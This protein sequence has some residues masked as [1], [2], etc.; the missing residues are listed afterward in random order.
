VSAATGLEIAVIGMSCRVPGAAG[1]EGFWDNLRAGRESISFFSEE[2]LLAAGHS[3]DAIRHPDYVPAAGTLEGIDRFD[4]EFFGY[5]P[6]EAQLIDPQQRLFLEQAWAA[7]ERAGYDPGRAGGPVGVFGGSSA[8]TYLFTLLGNPALWELANAYQTGLEKDFLATRVAYKLDL[9]G[10][11]VV[12]QTACSSSLAAIHLACQSLL[13][14]ECDM[15]LAGGVSVSVPQVS[16]YRYAVDGIRSRDGHCRPFDAAATGAVKGSGVGVVV[17]KRLSDAQRDRDPIEAV[18]RGSAMNN[19]GARKVGYTAPRVEGQCRVIEAALALAEVPPE[20]VGYVEA[21]GTGTALGDPIEVAALTQAFGRDG[22]TGRCALGSVKSNIG[23]LDAAAGV[24]GLIKAALMLKHRQMV[25]SLHFESPNPRLKLESSPFRIS[26]RSEP[27]A[28]DGVPRRCGVSSFGIGGTNVHVVL[29]EAPQADPPRDGSG[30]HLLILSARTASALEHQTR[31]L[32]VH[33]SDHPDLRLEDV[34][35]T[36]REG[37]RVFPHRRAVVVED[38]RAALGRLTGKQGALTSGLASETPPPVAFLFPGQGAQHPGMAEGLYEAHALFRQELDECCKVLESHLGLDL[39]TAL[40]PEGS[41]RDEAARSLAETRLTQPALFAVEYALA[42]LWMSWGVTPRAMIGHSIGEYV[43]ASLA[44]V[45][46]RDDALGLVA[47]RGRLM[48]SC[49]R[50]AMLAVAA[51]PAD[52]QDRLGGSLVVAVHNAPDACVVAGP[53]EDVLLLE[54]QLRQDQTAAARVAT[55]HAFHSPM[56]EGIVDEY[57]NRVAQVPLKSP[58]IPFLSNLTGTWITDGEAIDPRYWA[59]H[60]RETVRFEEGLG[61]LLEDRPH[62]LVEVGPGQTLSTLAR[63]RLG[64]ES[65]SRV[66]AS[67]PHRRQS[68]ADDV[69]LLAAAGRLWVEGVAVEWSGGDSP[70]RRVVLPTY[71][72]EGKRH[73]AD[74]PSRAAKPDVEREPIDRWFHAPV[75]R[76]HPP[77]SATVPAGESV[78]VLA[79]EEVGEAVAG[80]LAASGVRVTVA[81]PGPAPKR[82]PDGGFVV[83]PG[84]AADLQQVSEALER[85]GAP[86]SKVVHLWGLAHGEADDERMETGFFTVVALG[87]ILPRLAAP[88]TLTVVTRGAQ[89]VTGGETLDPLAALSLGPCRVIPQEH[90]DVTC[91]SV[92]VIVGSLQRRVAEAIVAEVFGP[93]DEVAVAYRGGYRWTQAFERVNVSRAGPQPLRKEGVYLIT[94]GLGEVGLDVAT[95]LARSA[96]ARLVLTSR[97][98]LPP[99]KEWAGWLREHPDSDPTGTT[100]RAVSRLHELGAE[101]LVMA[102][103]VGDREAMQRV[104]A[105]ARERF[106]AVNGV[107]HAAG[108]RDA[109]RLVARLDRD[110]ALRQ[111]W[112]K[113][114]GVRVLEELAAGEDF[115]FVCLTSSLASILGGLGFAA[116]AAANQFLDL[117]AHARCRQSRVPWLSVNWDGWRSRAASKADGRQP[118]TAEEGGEAFELALRQAGQPQLAVSTVDLDTR[119]AEWVERRS[120]AAPGVE[121]SSTHSRPE[122][123]TVFVAPESRVE[124]RLAEVWGILLGIDRVG[125]DDNF[126]E[127]GGSSLLAV[128]LVARLRNELR[129]ELSVATLFEAPTVRSLAKRLGSGPAPDEGLGRSHER[130]QARKDIRSRRTLDA[131]TR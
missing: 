82:C 8:S 83:R 75:W 32:A 54:E 45:V 33:L 93:G 80:V 58:R 63:R 2:E 3:A 44:G 21:H 23:H 87:Q 30:P 13:A 113:V 72:F 56:M 68:E 59:R 69:S 9:E 92:D 35:F 61:R 101:V 125:V 14:G 128:Q 43:A 95:H 29:E 127:L 11:A 105:S 26:D 109:V 66:V 98:G 38:L 46:S 126:F 6:R 120:L 39:R 131:S 86:P 78:L 76:R 89:D 52:V 84:R 41:Q 60:L 64:S 10:P 53:E 110:E 57:A 102:A 100:I 73:W 88:T 17:L 85:D 49:P 42:R 24:V 22:R 15:A 116:Y 36:L 31:E 103:D 90:P 91:R 112:P 47:E 25:P 50:G 94:G 12:V 7:V 48:Q 77:L 5:T 97:R 65:P 18:I 40:F 1:V 4:A 117:F 111:L 108:I 115:D 123:H 96:K 124:R 122:L 27:W 119:L 28:A 106:G 34:A 118:I 129:V 99:R 62:V 51:G 107:V 114:E 74:P 19:D 130:G 70:A 71:P 16:G 67:L 121:P 104:L 55:S 81:R 79:A 20:T 37:R